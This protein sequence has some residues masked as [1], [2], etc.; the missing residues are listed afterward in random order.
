MTLELKDNVHVLTL[1]NTEQ[2][3]MFT[4]DVLN[5]YLTAF[6]EVESYQGNTALM[7]TCEHEKTFCNGIN[8]QWG[9][10][11]SEAIAKTF[12]KTLETVLYRLAM[13]NAPSVCC[14][15]GNAYAGGAILAAAADY[16]IM[17]EDKGRFCFPEINLKIPFTPMMYDII[18]L[19]PNK[20]ILQDMALRGK[21]LTGVECKAADVV[22]ELLPQHEL[23]NKTLSYTKELAELDRVTYT[24]IKH[25]L[26][27]DVAKHKE[28]RTKNKEQ[29]LG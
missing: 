7:I 17:R 3:N 28:Q 1:T 29:I 15:N 22:H 18:N 19:L 10:S 9:L 4:Q 2:E 11:Q 25:G 21:A 5:E 26:R 14:I 27:A 8:L 20:H 13:L 6:D 24:T 23:Q 16:R 12:I